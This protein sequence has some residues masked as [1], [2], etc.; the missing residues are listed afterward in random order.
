MTRRMTAE[1]P[2]EKEIELPLRSAEFISDCGCFSLASG[3]AEAAAKIEGLTG[4]DHS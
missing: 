2:I 3:F 1:D 4:A